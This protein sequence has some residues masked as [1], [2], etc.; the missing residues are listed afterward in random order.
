MSTP[1]SPETP[2]SD[3]SP[4]DD[5]EEFDGDLA[6]ESTIEPAE[7]ERGTGSLAAFTGGDV[8]SADVARLSDLD[9]DA[10][11][12]FTTEWATLP[13]ETRERIVRT[14]D[15]L[16]ED[17]LDLAFGRVLRVALDDPS[18]VVRQLAIT[19]LWEDERQ[20]LI[21]PLRD[22]LNHDPSQDVRSAAARGLATFVR[23]AD[24]GELPESTGQQ[25]RENLIAVARDD[26]LPDALRQRA[27]ESVAIFALSPEIRDLILDAYESDDQAWQSSAL[28]SM[29][30]SQDSGW[31]PTAID[32]LANPDAQLR[33]EAARACGAIGDEAA[34]PELLER[35]DDEDAEV[36]QAVIAALGQIGGR[37]AVRALQSLST[38]ADETDHE[39]IEAALEEASATSDPVGRGA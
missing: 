16:C 18:P 30:Q 29:A 4:V 19:A 5:T 11:A 6:D 26:R 22:L 31:L 20:D 9:R 14:M 15:E 38:N 13:E 27:L 1:T 37:V 28:F 33:Y 32:E 10:A 35:A 3:G 25:L 39:A 36:R 8:R 24:A 12:Q 23:L 17:R 7:R 34:V 2:P 21:E